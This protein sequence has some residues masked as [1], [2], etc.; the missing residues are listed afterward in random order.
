MIE[1]IK[2]KYRKYLGIELE[3]IIGDKN[4][5]YVFVEELLYSLNSHKDLIGEFEME[6]FRCTI[7]YVTPPCKNDL[8]AIE[9]IKHDMEILNDT[10]EKFKF[11]IIQGDHFEIN[12]TFFRHDAGELKHTLNQGFKNIF[13]P[14]MHVHFGISSLKEAK[15]VYNRWVLDFDKF[16]NFYNNKDSYRQ[17]KIRD[18]NLTFNG[19]SRPHLILKEFELP[20]RQMDFIG[21]DGNNFFPFRYFYY[22][23]TKHGTVENRVSDFCSDINKMFE[24]IKYLYKISCECID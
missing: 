23:Y 14:S 4:N 3:F 1:Y 16:S 7:E 8:V 5:N 20:F 21:D 11:K 15:N 12:K 19:K 6:A 10:L 13:T 9:T 18:I 24:Y 2:K 22:L 17:R